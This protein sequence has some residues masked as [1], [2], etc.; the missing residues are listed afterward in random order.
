MPKRRRKH[1]GPR[2]PRKGLDQARTKPFAA[3]AAI[4]CLVVISPW[5]IRNY[6]AFGQ[7]VPVRTGGA[8]Q[9]WI[10]NA[11]ISD[12]WIDAGVPPV[13]PY[14][15]PAE[16]KVLLTIGEPAYNDLA[17]KRF[18][19]GLV[20]N[21][22]GYVASC[23]RRASY[24]LVGK[25]T[26]ARYPLFVD[27]KWRG[28]FWGPLLLNAFVALLGV[29]GMVAARRFHYRQSGLP[30]PAASVALPFVATAVSNRYTL[31]LRWLL[32]VYSGFCGWL[33][34]RWYQQ[35]SGVLSEQRAEEPA[36]VRA[37]THP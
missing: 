13:H 8:L 4:T 27:W 10:G 18:E 6:A 24:M 30:V 20:A 7:L 29:A 35:R 1:R 3:V 37:R 36:S 19:N 28:V 2:T 26:A 17:F 25:P 32:I 14:V 16:G 23:L 21:P 22:L 9:L 34:F 11:P 5:T 12:G 15:N 31:P 33:I